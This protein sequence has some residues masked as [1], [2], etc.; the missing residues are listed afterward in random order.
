MVQEELA[1]HE[2]KGEEV[3]GPG[4]NKEAADFVVERDF[5]WTSGRADTL[6]G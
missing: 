2:E 1:L 3:E 5:G 6:N 4:E